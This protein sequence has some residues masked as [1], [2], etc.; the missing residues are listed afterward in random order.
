MGQN[1][2]NAFW[3]SLAAVVG[4]ADSTTNNWRIK[5]RACWK[6][7]LLGKVKLKSWLW[8]TPAKRDANGSG[9]LYTWT[10]FV[11]GF[12]ARLRARF[13]TDALVG[14]GPERW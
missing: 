13:E 10:S 4:F 8:A 5:P 11:P 3:L 6:K 1:P 7:R 9:G 14:G 2:K 12:F